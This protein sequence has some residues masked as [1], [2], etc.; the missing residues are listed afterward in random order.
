MGFGGLSRALLVLIIV[1]FVTLVGRNVVMVSLLGLVL[2]LD[3]LL[4]LFRYPSKSG[5]ACST[6]DLAVAGFWS[7]WYLSCCSL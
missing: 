3:E 7:C 2:F 4:S 1:D 6:P 5:R